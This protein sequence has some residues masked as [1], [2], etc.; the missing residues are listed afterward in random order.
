MFPSSRKLHS[1]KIA[2]SEE[3]VCEIKKADEGEHQPSGLLHPQPKNVQL[4]IKF[5]ARARR[6]REDLPVNFCLWRHLSRA[7]LLQPGARGPVCGLGE[8]D[9]VTIMSKDIGCCTRN[10]G[11]M[12]LAAARNSN[13]AHPPPCRLPATLSA[14]QLASVP[15][16]LQA[17]APTPN[18]Q[19]KRALWPE[20]MHLWWRQMLL[21]AAWA[22]Q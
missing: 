21:P 19:G 17:E 2:S 7:L 9:N 1:A 11:A 20:S 12:D 10:S 4:Y 3:N 14:P 18:T 22:G 5:R 6:V 16:A 15:L 8:Q 13:W